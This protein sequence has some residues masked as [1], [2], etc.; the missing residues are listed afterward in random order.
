MKIKLIKAREI[1]D[2]RGIPTVEVDLMT[3]DGLFRASVPSGSSTGKYEAFEL[4]DV[5]K[6][7][8]HGLGV[9]QAVKNVNQLIAPKVKGMNVIE[10]G[11]IDGLMIRLDGT[12][13]KS[14]LGANAILGVSMAVCRAG[15]A[16][17]KMPLWKWISKLSGTKPKL[18]VPCILFIEGG[19]HGRG[20]LDIQEFMAVSQAKSFKEN[21]RIGVEIYYNL[22]KILIKKYGASSINVGIEGAFT[23]SIKKTR[24]ALDLLMEA[25]KKS[26]YQA[27]IKII[28]DVAASS[29]FKKGKYDFEKGLLT[30]EQLLSFYLRLLKDYP[31]I[32]IEDPFTEEDWKGFEK[33]TERVGKKITIIG[34]DL[35][36]TNVKRMK[37]AQDKNACNGV[38]IKLNQIGTVSET[39]QAAQYAM[40]NKWQVFVKHRGGETEDS[41]IAD[42]SVGL[43]TGWIMAGAPS[44]GERVAKYNRL[45][46]IEQEF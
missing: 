25:A 30:K 31:I 6:K 10:Q 3:I 42:L 46:K 4:R 33:I 45:L 34:D 12:E 17:K 2:S 7:R 14:K 32:A 16:A 18:P 5:K 35:L 38:I 21:L 11:K 19:L 37:K 44:R 1:L 36:V 27:K 23:P 13:N 41:F 40:E 39:I 24:Q 8:Y 28:L 22:K 26:G 15:A 20:D 43:G 9:E 29:L